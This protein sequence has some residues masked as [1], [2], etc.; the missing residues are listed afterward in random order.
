MHCQSV[1]HPS[2]DRKGEGETRRR[3]PFI[4]GTGDAG[5]HA[6]G[7]DILQAQVAAG[8]DNPEVNTGICDMNMKRRILL[9]IMTGRKGG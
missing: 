4:F 6:R 8:R 9:L 1:A 7:L 2:S 5:Q 3:K